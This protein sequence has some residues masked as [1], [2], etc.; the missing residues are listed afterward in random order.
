MSPTSYPRPR[1]RRRPKTDV[2]RN[3]T[4]RQRTRHLGYLLQ[5]AGVMQ[6]GPVSMIELTCRDTLTRAQWNRAF[7]DWCELARAAG[8]ITWAIGIHHTRGPKGGKAKPHVHLLCDLHPDARRRLRLH[9]AKTS[10]RH[11][12]FDTVRL[13]Q[14]GLKLADLATRV[15]VDQRTHWRV[16]DNGGPGYLHG[17]QTEG[18]RPWT[19]NAETVSTFIPHADSDEHRRI[20]A[21]MRET[22]N[23]EHAVEMARTLLAER[24]DRSEAQSPADH[25][26]PEPRPLPP[27]TAPARQAKLTAWNGLI[28]K[29]IDD[30]CITTIPSTDFGPDRP[31]LRRSDALDDLYDWCDEHD[32]R[33]PPRRDFVQA[34][35]AAFA[36]HDGYWDRIALRDQPL[37]ADDVWTFDPPPS[38]K[39]VEPAPI[40][41]MP[42]LPPGVTPHPS[43]IPKRYPSHIDEATG[44]VLDPNE[45]MALREAEDVMV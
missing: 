44:R 2:E 33:R 40:P 9:I 22:P 27:S 43:T 31:V 5:L 17:R 26:R 25:D 4:Y 6:H 3:R 19:H 29:W 23:D 15:G 36:T 35:D 32:L 1:R 20:I 30:R 34:M 21:A 8:A 42:E 14:H 28:T 7:H 39:P 13:D 24:S 38:R 12:R 18:R 37:R 41:P 11:R 45:W 10:A 16:I